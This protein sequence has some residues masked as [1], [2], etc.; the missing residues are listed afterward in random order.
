MTSGP[1]GPV[2]C[3]F[4]RY[5][6]SMLNVP[7]INGSFS[8]MNHIKAVA[9]V[10]EGE[11]GEI[12]TGTGVDI[13]QPAPPPVGWAELLPNGHH[14]GVTYDL[15]GRVVTDIKK[16]TIYIRNMEKFIHF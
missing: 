7:F 1:V 13:T 4:N 9:C 10:T 5:I 12:I 3:R 16:N 15:Y 11:Y 14:T 6:E 2:H 8:E